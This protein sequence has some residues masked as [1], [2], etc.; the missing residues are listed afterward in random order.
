[1][2]ARHLATVTVATAICLGLAG[3]A[4]AAQP[5]SGSDGPVG[6]IVRELPG[7]GDRPERAVQAFGGTVSRQLSIIGAFTAS[8][9]R[10]RLAALRPV[11]PPPVESSE[12]RTAQVGRRIPAPVRV[13]LVVLLLLPQL[14]GQMMKSK[15]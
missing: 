15:H 10:D 6:V 5:T 2:T 13:A 7:S 4:A 14:S 12:T 11:P 8:V 1:M 3:P 9:P